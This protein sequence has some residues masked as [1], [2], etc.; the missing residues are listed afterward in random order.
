MHVCDHSNEKYLALFLYGT[1][2]F[3][4]FCD[5][6]LGSFSIDKMAKIIIDLVVS[7]FVLLEL[8]NV[9]RGTWMFVAYIKKLVL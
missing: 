4:M 2:Y 6:I 7:M 1:I 8:P 3:S 5:R 9:S